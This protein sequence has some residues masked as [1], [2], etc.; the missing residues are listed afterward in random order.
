MVGSCGKMPSLYGNS[1]TPQLMN[2]EHADMVYTLILSFH[3]TLGYGSAMVTVFG[4]PNE[5]SCVQAGEKWKKDEPLAQKRQFT[6]VA[7]PGE[8]R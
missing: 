4:F 6:C 3:L 2:S 1:S 5:A 7:H 8:V